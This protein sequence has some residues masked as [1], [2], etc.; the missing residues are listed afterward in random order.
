LQVATDRH[1]NPTEIQF[2]QS[3]YPKIKDISSKLEGYKQNATSAK[4]KLIEHYQS[5]LKIMDGLANI[6]YPITA[7]APTDNQEGKILSRILFSSIADN[8]ETYL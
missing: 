2:N 6:L 7:D 5:I 8:F 1:E 3:G 4:S